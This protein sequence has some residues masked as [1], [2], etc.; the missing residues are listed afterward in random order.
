LFLGGHHSFQRA[1]IEQYKSGK[2]IARWVKDLDDRVP[3]GVWI[4]KL[5][6]VPPILLGLL[7]A[8]AFVEI[9]NT[10]SGDK[11]H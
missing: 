7:I 9:K 4:W 6:W 5:R 2:Y 11:H 3:L 10:T 8:Y 1:F